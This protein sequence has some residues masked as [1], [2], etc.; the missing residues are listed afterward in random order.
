MGVG[1]HLQIAA[2][3]REIGLGSTQQGKG[4]DRAVGRYRRQ[5]DSPAFTSEGFGHR[6]DHLVIVAS[7]RSDRNS[8][9]FRPQRVIQC[10]C[11]GT[12]T[13][14]SNDQHQQQGIPPPPA[15]AR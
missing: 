5:S 6:L 12:K 9:G 13:K 3:D 8:E 15:P 14:E 11:G 2:G 4:F 10:A 1:R 7:L